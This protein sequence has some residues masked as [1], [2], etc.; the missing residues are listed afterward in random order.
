MMLETEYVPRR[1]NTVSANDEEDKD[2]PPKK[3]RGENLSLGWYVIS[4]DM[5][6]FANF[7]RESGDEWVALG[8][9]KLLVGQKIFEK[10]VE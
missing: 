6:R 4:G 1:D 10:E 9:K 7:I 3:K 5:D 8:R 2:I